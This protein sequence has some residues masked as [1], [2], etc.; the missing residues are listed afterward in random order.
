MKVLVTGASGYVGSVVCKNLWVQNNTVVAMDR[1]PCLHNY[2]SESYTG[3]FNDIQNLLLDIDCVVHCAATSLVGPSIKDPA[4]YYKNNV[5]GTQELLDA[6]V[7]QGI[8]RFVFIS[9]AACY[10]N[11]ENGICDI[12]DTVTP[13]NPYGW[14]KRMTEIM[15]QD[16]YTAYGLNSV[17]LR[18][19][20]VAGADNE[21][22]QA[23]QATH[24]IARIMES[25]MAEETFTLFGD[26]F[27][28][29]DGTCVRDYIHVSDVARAVESA[30]RFTEDCSSASIFNVGNSDG[31]S[32]LDIIRAVEKN[33]TL[34]VKYK[35]GPRR[36]GDPDYLVADTTATQNQLNWQPS[37]TLDDIVTSAYNY[38]NLK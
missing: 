28:S 16:Y 18:L 33:T 38:Y 23:K 35:I 29:P 25:A 7:T 36:K 10:G 15:L 8:K 11:P 2:F 32:N 9:S 27:N 19:F 6:V 14:S 5:Q 12:L 24:I 3:N 34:D 4:K 37:L 13:I 21:L 31:Y 22:G 17:S 20:N 26:D 30:V 1:N